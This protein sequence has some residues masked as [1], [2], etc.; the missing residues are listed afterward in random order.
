MARPKLTPEQKAKIVA[1]KLLGIKRQHAGM[2][3]RARLARQKAM[4]EPTAT[5]KA[6][7]VI[8]Y[9]GRVHNYAAI[10]VE[11]IL[12]SVTCGNRP[13]G[14]TTIVLMGDFAQLQP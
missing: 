1:E 12:Q 10:D 8:I 14:G 2:A 4:Q 3:S 11:R 6:I 9:N 13:A 5:I 7:V